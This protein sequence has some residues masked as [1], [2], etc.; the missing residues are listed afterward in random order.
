MA[1]DEKSFELSH[2]DYFDIERV[3]RDV[4]KENGI[5]DVEEI[6]VV[7]TASEGVARF[8]IAKKKDEDEKKEKKDD[9]K[10]P[11]FWEKKKDDEEC[12]D[13]KNCGE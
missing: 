6:T 2:D 4:A 5:D 9:G 7:L 1:N 11:K 8:K 3:I 10:K 13:G 12:D